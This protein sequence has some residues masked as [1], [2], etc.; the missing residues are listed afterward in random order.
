M[1]VETLATR[2][3][4][5]K[6]PSSRRAPWFVRLVAHR[7]ATRVV[8]WACVLSF[9]TLALFVL[10]VEGKLLAVDREV[11]TS[12]LGARSGSLNTTMVVL[13]FLGTRWVIGAITL[14]LVVWS[15]YTGKARPLTAVIVAAVLINPMFELGFKELI[16]RVRPDTAQLVAGRGPS[17]P[18]GH[19]LASVGFYGMLPLLVWEATH[20]R[21]A[22]L[23]ALIGSLALILTIAVSR[24]YL[25]VH[26][27]SDVVAGM[28]LGTALVVAAGHIH[29]AWLQAT[30]APNPDSDRSPPRA[31][32]LG[33]RFPPSFLRPRLVDG[34]LHGFT[35][36]R[37]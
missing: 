22:Q 14:G 10:I 2:A 32:T 23:G 33:N 30:P 11:Q 20:S 29:H 17:F 35:L 34:S 13:T 28:L 27:T 8:A 4:G 9:T 3:L 1:T 21:I 36:V 37:L 25:D 7:R 31:V 26:W 15:L 16:D 5:R 12:V 6:L 18:S 19:V 24:V